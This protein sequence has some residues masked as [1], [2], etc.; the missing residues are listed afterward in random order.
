MRALSLL[1]QKDLRL[2][3]RDP[4]GVA[5]TFLM[6][7]LFAILF[8]F[9]FRE[10]HTGRTQLR[11]AVVEAGSDVRARGLGQSL[12]HAA[13]LRV[14]QLSSADAR[15]ALHDGT[16]EAYVELGRAEAPVA[17]VHAPGSE[18]TATL[19]RGALLQAMVEAQA[20][21]LPGILPV[22]VRANTGGHA[23]PSASP[24]DASLAL[25]MVWGIVCCASVFGVSLVVERQRKTLER[26]CTL[27]ISTAHVLLAK[28]IACCVAIVLVECALVVVAMVWFDVRPLSLGLLFVA[29]VCSG[30]GFGG[31]TLALAAL[32]PTERAA[33]G[34]AWGVLTLL[35]MVGGGTVP[36]SQMPAWM[37]SLSRVSPFHWAVLAVEGAVWRGFSMTE[38]A[39][40][41][42]ALLLTGA[43]CFLLGTQV[44]RET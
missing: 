28:A 25:G 23:A 12:T 4:L 43:A 32:S 13:G 34:L 5:V 16:L 42:A 7:L 11:V 19:L 44:F 22:S 9:V 24:F 37:L 14:A 17:V 2:L 1:V 3:F 30:L 33:T 20:T 21:P 15:A 6:P 39:A 8:G 35:A 10:A 38:M 27:P 41:C 31:L 18:L 36:L 29:S 26:L 40:P